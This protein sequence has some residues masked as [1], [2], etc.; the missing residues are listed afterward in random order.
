MKKKN[1]NK[2]TVCETTSIVP[3]CGNESK[4]EIMRYKYW[5]IACYHYVIR[6]RELKKP[7]DMAYYSC[8]AFVKVHLLLGVTVTKGLA[9]QTSVS[10]TF[11]GRRRYMK[12]RWYVNRGGSLRYS[13][14]VAVTVLVPAFATLSISSTLYSMVLS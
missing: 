12:N 10:R 7:T 4:T 2:V 9:S 14:S 1:F 13:F 6:L 5:E 3:V 8:Y 11:Q